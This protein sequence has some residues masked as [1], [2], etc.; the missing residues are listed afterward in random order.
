MRIVSDFCDNMTKKEKEIVMRKLSYF[1]K[2]IRQTNCVQDIPSGFWIR[3]ILGTNIYKFRVNN[4]DRILFTFDNNNNYEVV[5]LMYCNHDSQI[6]KGKSIDT[7][8]NKFLQNSIDLDF[9]PYEEE[10]DI[11]KNNEDIIKTYINR[12]SS[13]GLE[14]LAS[15]VIE[16]EY[17]SL[18]LEDEYMNYLNKSQF[19]CL[20][21]IGKPLIVS[22]C[23]GSGKSLIGIHKMMLNSEANIKSAYICYS[24][25][26]RNKSKE[27]YDKFNKHKSDKIDF[28]TLNEL[29]C[30]LLGLD[31]KKILTLVHFQRWYFFRFNNLDINLPIA[32]IYSEINK[33]RKNKNMGISSDLKIVYREYLNWIKS[34]NL[35]DEF[36]LFEK[37]CEYVKNNG[38][39]DNKY[40]FIFIDEV[41]DFSQ[42]NII[43]IFDFCNDSQNIIFAGDKNQIINNSG[44]DFKYIKKKLYS[45]GLDYEEK[46]INKNYRNT[47]G[48]VNFIN[49]IIDIRIDSMG[50]S[51]DLHDLHEEYVREGNK[52]VLSEYKSFESNSILKDIRDKE[53]CAIVVPSYQEKN[54]LM[55]GGVPETRIFTIDEIKGLEYKTIFCI[56]FISSNKKYWD[57]INK[58]K[59][60][61]DVNLRYSLNSLYVAI[62]RGTSNVI[63]LEENS[64]YVEKL[65]NDEIF[66]YLE[67]LSLKNNYIEEAS[68]TR[69]WEKE[70][71]RLEASRLYDKAIYAYTMA[72][73]QEA[74]E[75]CKIADKN[76][77]DSFKRVFGVENETSIRIESSSYMITPK[78]VYYI[79]YDFF[80]RYGVY[81][82]GKIEIVVL[83]ELGMKN[84]YV[85]CNNKE[86]SIEE[87]CIAYKEILDSDN[88]PGNKKVTFKVDLM[89]NGYNYRF[90]TVAGKDSNLIRINI[91]REWKYENSYGVSFE[92]I[93]SLYSG[94]A[95]EEFLRNLLGGKF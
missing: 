73:N 86:S 58:N 64:K 24:D 80:V 85:E 75:R 34:E 18:F 89:K 79:L 57:M 10:D 74:A 16:D 55:V 11:D 81:T 41:Q 56:N 50:K 21:I 52:P 14:N 51:K 87:I 45:S 46:Y 60:S 8:V 49:N 84:T 13:V 63:L 33:K 66:D 91:G 4:G 95:F 35:I 37:Y 3:R 47:S 78:D 27:Y 42:D 72:G 90:K 48:V 17:I 9:N 29:Y 26:L 1:E 71:E 43:S 76:M 70:G 23:A 20:K 61:N 30:N 40:D 54:R 19:E 65:F 2:C 31:D 88:K 22:G 15:I 69:N 32:F 6:D 5:F 94:K 68:T 62:T 44:F 77:E 7:N 28:L 38:L 12:Y 53:Y 67:E 83:D 93:E 25:L 36:L 82:Q 59:R 92:Y 39:I